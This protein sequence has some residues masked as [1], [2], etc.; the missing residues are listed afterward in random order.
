M[1]THV[2]EYIHKDNLEVVAYRTSSHV[3]TQRNTID[4]PKLNTN[5]QVILF[6]F[7]CEMIRYANKQRQVGEH[8]HIRG[9]AH[10]YRQH[11]DVLLV[12]T[13]T[14]LF[15]IFFSLSKL[16]SLFY[17][18]QFLFIVFLFV[19]QITDFNLG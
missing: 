6:F 14:A 19:L 12:A 1:Q 17:I 11:Y 4:V 2:P 15:Q 16:I 9:L 10:E 13:A 7:F 8:T 5:D 3:D 18:T